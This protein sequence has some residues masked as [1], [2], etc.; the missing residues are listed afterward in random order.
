MAHINAT[1]GGRV[2]LDT[3]YIIT[4][5]KTRFVVIENVNIFGTP[6]KMLCV[7]Q[8]K[9]FSK[10]VYLTNYKTFLRKFFFKTMLIFF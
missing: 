6:S 4:I 1:D 3:L 2:V 8:L 9:F 10:I 5:S 7:L